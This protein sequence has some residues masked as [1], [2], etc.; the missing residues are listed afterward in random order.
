MF[1]A[2]LPFVFAHISYGLLVPLSIKLAGIFGTRNS[3]IL[4][5]II[6]I[7]G[8]IPIVFYEMN[9]DVLWVLVWF[10]IYYFAK[11]FFHPSTIFVL[12]KSTDHQHRGTQFSLRS[13]TFILTSIIAPL[14][15]AYISD[16]YGVAY[17]TIF[18]CVLMLL[19][20]FP[21]LFMNNY[22]FNAG[23]N[24]FRYLRR[25]NVRKLLAL[26]LFS[27]IERSGGYRLWIIWLFILLGSSYNSFGLFLTLTS[28]IS[29]GLTYILGRIMDRHSRKKILKELFVISGIWN[30]VKA[31]S[32]N[33]IPLLLLESIGKFFIELKHQAT[34]VV[35]YDLLND[36]VN[37][38]D[39]DEMVAIKESS[40]NASI[41]VAFFITGLT[42]Q[43]FGFEISLIFVGFVNLLWVVIRR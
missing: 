36:E 14:I 20:I 26:G 43:L 34:T 16:V 22:K 29:I 31:L 25:G 18:G 17:I 38:T 40:L 41:A 12:G 15:G 4:S 9:G 28:I 42:A 33:I 8:G 27:E 39:R 3:L 1:F 2:F 11:L 10:G 37:S 7:S 6:F 32:V 19:A 24:L 5:M 23:L 35:T 21:L 30:I 13:I